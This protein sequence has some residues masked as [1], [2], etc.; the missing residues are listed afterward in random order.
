MR[1]PEVDG[2]TPKEVVNSKRGDS[3]GRRLQ[4]LQGFFQALEILRGGEDG[5]IGVSAKFGSAVQ[6]ARLAADE[7][8]LDTVR[9]E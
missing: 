6:Y 5:D 7:Q 9:G 2:M 8:A 4:L 1:T 3:Y